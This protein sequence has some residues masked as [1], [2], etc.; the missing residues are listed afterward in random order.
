M[1]QQVTAEDF[2]TYLG[3]TS[4]KVDRANLILQ[5]AQSACEQIVNPVPDAKLFVL[6]RVAERAY[7]AGRNQ[8]RGYQYAAAGVDDGG[9]PSAAGVYLTPQDR[10]DLEPADSGGGPGGVFSVSILPT[11]YVLPYTFTDA[12]DWDVIGSGG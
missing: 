1:P 8:G 2:G 3:D 10:A 5:Q 11:D 7:T 6:Y 9:L 12:G 4:L